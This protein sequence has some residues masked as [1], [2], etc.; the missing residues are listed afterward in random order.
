MKAEIIQFNQIQFESD[1]CICCG[2]T[3]TNTKGFCE[4]C[5]DDITKDEWLP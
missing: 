5:D 2:N 3:I 4:V 1:E